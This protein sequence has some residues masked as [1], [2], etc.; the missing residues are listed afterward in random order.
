MRII[1]LSYRKIIDI[2]AQ[3]PWE[4]LVYDDSYLEFKIQAQNFTIGTDHTTYAQL[5]QNIPAAKKLGGMVSAS[6]SGYIQQLNNIV[7]D[8]LNNLGRRF[9]KFDKYQFEIINSDILDIGKHQVAINFFSGPMIW[10][11]TVDNMLLVSEYRAAHAGNETLTYLFTIQ[12]YVNIHSL[13]NT[14]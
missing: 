5:I 2:T 8:I 13:K 11:D 3:K 9:I 7:P 1:T 14:Y 4:K 12:P 10:H 6:V